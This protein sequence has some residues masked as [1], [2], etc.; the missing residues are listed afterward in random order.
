M[1]NEVYQVI[2]DSHSMVRNGDSF[3]DLGQSYRVASGEIRYIYVAAFAPL[4]LPSDERSHHLTERTLLVVDGPLH[5]INNLERLA[6]ET[7]GLTLATTPLR[8]VQPLTQ[9][10]EVSVRASTFKSVVSN[11][12]FNVGFELHDN[13]FQEIKEHLAF[14]ML[15]YTILVGLCLMGIIHAVFRFKLINPL[16][17]LITEINEGGLQLRYFKR[18]KEKDEVS[19]LKNAYIDSLTKVKFE[20]EFDGLTKLAN[21]NSF[22][23]HIKRRMESFSLKHTYVVCWDIKDFR[24][25]NDLYG[26]KLGDRLLIQF[27]SRI[28][29]QVTRHQANYGFGCS[30]YSIA[31]FSGN[32]FYAVIESNDEVDVS[33]SIE[34]I[35]K[36]LCGELKIDNFRFSVRLAISIYPLDLQQDRSLWYKGTEEALLIAKR[37]KADNSIVLV[38]EKIVQQLARRKDIERLLLESIDDD[39]FV[40]NFMPLFDAKS[41]KIAGFEVLL[42]CP[43]L[44]AIDSGPEEF[45]PI[46]EKADLITK[47]DYWVFH[48]ALE[49]L[50]LLRREIQYTGT[51]SINISALE[52]YNRSFTEDILRATEVAGIPSH[53]VTLELTETSYVKSSD[54]TTNMIANL[55]EKGF[56]ISIDDFGT[57]YASI[58]QLL[59]YPVDELKVD[60]EFVS[61]LDN[62]D[63]DKSMLNAIAALAHACG[64]KVVGEGVESAY[65]CE[66]LRQI[67]CNYLQGYYLS[68][69][70]TLNQ[71]KQFV[72]EYDASDTLKQVGSMTVLKR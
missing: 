29:K 52:L 70:L 36:Q 53:I 15:V 14:Q 30:D 8:V 7:K 45:I 49:T 13:Y 32:Q 2:F 31:R 63:N 33:Q 71:F 20:A 67:D 4:L 9:S 43:R 27:A 72:V 38:D 65:Q 54:E 57:G 58:N 17:A 26:T 11:R 18:T 22:I 10:V 3:V 46:A 66:Y 21:R 64:A 24:K 61:N 47:I 25:V 48:H 23:T 50:A 1:P 34:D 12:Y 55:R 39:G 51:M 28:K 68:K 69:P 5:Q 37:F 42:R 44:L 35:N 62:N 16:I 60:K 19:I 40:L 56:K 6:K 59:R 41:L